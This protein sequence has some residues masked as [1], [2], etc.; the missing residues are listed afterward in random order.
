MKE[1]R[2]DC[3]C[4]QYTNDSNIYKHCKTTSIEQNIVKLEKILN[5]VYKWSIFNP[6]KT[7]FTIFTTNKSKIRN[8]DFDFHPD[9]ATTLTR[10]ISTKI[11]GV[12]FQQQLNWDDHIT[13]LLK[14]CYATLSA[15]RKIKRPALFN[16]RKHL[17]ESLVPSKFDYCSSVFDP[18]TIIQQRRL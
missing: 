4:V 5:E 14:T 13:E 11:I 3:I 1:I 18:L 8:T 6:G 2:D 16:I 15:L 9:N 10:T 12:H 17:C 7:K